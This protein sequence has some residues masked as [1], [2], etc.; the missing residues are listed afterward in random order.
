MLLCYY[1]GVYIGWP[2]YFNVDQIFDYAVNLITVF[3][4]RTSLKLLSSAVE[5]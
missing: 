5:P 3:C 2:A 1:S 4:I